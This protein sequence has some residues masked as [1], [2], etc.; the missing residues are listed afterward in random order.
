MTEED[1]NLLTLSPDRDDCDAVSVSWANN[2]LLISKLDSLA[3]SM[4]TAY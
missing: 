1:S 4:S 3:F 2:L